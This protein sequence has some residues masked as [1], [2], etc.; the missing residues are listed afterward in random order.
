M[1]KFTT[2]LLA[3]S[4][5]GM[6]ACK[7]D[8][9]GKDPI[10]EPTNDMVTL[11]GEINS[12]MKLDASKKYLLSGIVYVTNGAKLSIPAGT[13]VYGE[14]LTKGAL[15]ITQGSSIEAKGEPNKPIIFTSN[16]PAG[17]R[18]TGDWAGVVILGKA[19][20]NLGLNQSIEG[21]SAGT[22]NASHGGDNDA[23]N[24][25]I[26]QY[27]RIE[28]AGIALSPDNELNSLTMGSV[29]SGTTI[30]HIQ[31]SY[32]GDDAYEWFG[33]TVSASYLVAYNTVD[34][35]FDT[36]M[37]YR[38]SVDYGVVVRHPSVADVSGSNGFEADNNKNTATLAPISAPT[39]D[40]ITVVG[41]YATKSKEI[42]ANYQHGGHL[43]RG[44]NIVIKN[45][46][47]AGWPIGVNFDVAGDNV[48]LD[49]VVIAKNKDAST[50]TFTKGTVPASA[51]IVEVADMTTVFTGSDWKNL[52]NPNVSAVTATYNTAGAFAGTPNWNWTNGWIE[53]DPINKA[54]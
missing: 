4:I 30:D 18:A 45:S 29:G 15:V 5:L 23:D 39:F 50:S 6:V 48:N 40:H 44:S 22:S 11:K 24:S 38:G 10:V 46:I 42:S 9:D 41:P 47:I 25:G 26:M 43:R 21:I 37:G 16:A 12:D 8:D 34:D 7:K 17:F 49:N 31:V 28:F 13:V 53:F 52:S 14:K 54:Y 33:G 51:D 3:A 27:V 19:K 2:L 20:N 1:K 36:D 35:D 32:A